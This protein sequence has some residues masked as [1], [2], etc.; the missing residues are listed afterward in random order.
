MT[1]QS[2]NIA[3]NL[4]IVLV[5][6]LPLSLHDC[7]FGIVDGRGLKCIASNGFIFIPN[8][9]KNWPIDTAVLMN[10]GKV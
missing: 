9:T 3:Q 1:F 8:F 6:L 7:H 4:R 10:G 5:L 2:S